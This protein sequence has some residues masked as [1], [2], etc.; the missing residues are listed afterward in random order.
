MKNS[1]KYALLF[2]VIIIGMLL[3]SCDSYLDV[4]P[5]GSLSK[6]VLANKKGVNNLLIGAY[7]ALSG[8]GPDGD[9][10][11]I[12]NANY[13]PAWFVS[14]SD[15]VWGSEAGGD[16]T[17][18]DPATFIDINPESD[19]LNDM[20]VSRYE[21]ISRTNAVLSTL[22]DV[23]GMSDEEKANIAGQARFL[24]GWYY[25]DLKKMFNM[26]PWIDENSKKGNG[27]KA[28]DIPNDK[29]IWPNI[30]ADLKFAMNNLPETQGEIGR[31]NKWAAE[32]YL[33][34]AY[35]FQ[36][37]YDSARTLF[38]DVINNGNTTSGKKYHL[39]ALFE[40]SF[41]AATE[42]NSG[43][44]FTVEMDAN[45]GSGGIAHA[46]GDMALNYPDQG[47]FSCCHTFLPSIDV[48]N[49]YRTNSKTGLPYLNSYNKHPL[50]NDMGI[51]SDESFTPDQGTIDPRL[52]W[53][54]GRR[55]IPYKDWGIDPGEAWTEGQQEYGPYLPKKM[56]YWHATMGKYYDG[57]QWAPG[58]AINQEVMRFAGVLLMAAE[59][60]AQTGNLDQAEKYVN[61]VRKRAANPAGWVHTYKDSDKPLEGFTNKPAANYFIKPY[62]K[63]DF[64][65][66]GKDFALKA[67][68]FERKLELAMEG[69]RFF[70]LVRWKIAAKILNNYFAFMSDKIDHLVDAHFTKGKNEYY[71]IPQRQIDLTT[72]NG[73]PTLTQNP[74]YH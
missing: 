6:Q 32:T 21:G 24:R 53:T 52:D 45:D 5:E 22:K 68:R 15:W 1:K 73:K 18:M 2:A 35:L 49:S 65:A 28:Y 42:N 27:A 54:I 30:D 34:K 39:P 43:V 70:D 62:P 69:K 31:V 72:I 13:G 71:P 37:K 23:K 61:R 20:W 56:L 57:S 29:N 67:I 8:A 19:E 7:S 40:D 25:F 12:I 47:P 36:D 10:G 16:A 64:A 48:A 51:S 44:V 17:D 14:P 66:K 60:E 74:G 3:Y 11:D 46:N 33:A 38:E 58:T 4:Q 59:A 26:V 55:G 9:Y 63:G 41:K 50:K